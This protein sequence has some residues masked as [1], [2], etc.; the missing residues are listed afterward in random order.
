[1][2]VTSQF[3]WLVIDYDLL[4]GDVSDNFRISFFSYEHEKYQDTDSI[5][6]SEVYC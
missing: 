6:L 3:I 2:K 1:M 4:S 5:I